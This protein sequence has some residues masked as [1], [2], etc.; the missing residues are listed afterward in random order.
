MW[1][2]EAKRHI[3]PHQAIFVLVGTK[4]TTYILILIRIIKSIFIIVGTKVTIF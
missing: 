3:A 4:V 1:I 2:M